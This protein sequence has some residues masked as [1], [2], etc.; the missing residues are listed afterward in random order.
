MFDS[1]EAI[2]RL[3]LTAAWFSGLASLAGRFAGGVG[4][5]L[6]L[7][8]VSRNIAMPLGVN[9]H[10]AITPDFLD[11]VLTE[12]RRLGYVFVTMDEVVERL[13]SGSTQRFA[14]VTADDAYRDNVS[15]ALPVLEHHGAPITIYVAPGLTE[16][17]VDLWWDVLE[18]IVAARDRLDLAT[19][20]GHIVIDCSSAVRKV[21]ANRTIHDYLTNEVP[22]EEQTT[23]LRMLARSAGV[24]PQRPARETLMDWDE[25]RAAAQHPLVTIGAHTMHHYNLMRLGKEKAR[26][27]IAEAADVIAL[28]T[29]VK[30]RHMAYPYGYRTAVGPREVALAREVGFV[31]AVTTRHGVLRST[32][33]DHLHALPRL[34]VNGRYQRVSHVRTML[35]GVTTPLANAGRIVV[36]V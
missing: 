18:E 5:I 11:A 25:I 13:R 2:R 36:T 35:S 28:K 3:A 1:R 20:A 24:D 30:P 34:S 16:G 26:R 22:E 9:R 32:H 21:K 19:P 33:A 12:L 29:G 17:T 7:H 15:E 31:T 23:V 14:T 6:M 8:R 27:E 10:L 4:A